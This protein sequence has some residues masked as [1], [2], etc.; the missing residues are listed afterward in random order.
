MA[1][2]R[3]IIAGQLEFGTERVFNQVLEQYTHRMEHY[4]KNDILLKPEDFFKPEDLALDVPR[5]VVIGSERDWL[6]TLNLLERVVSFSMAGSIN[7]WRLSAGNIMD[8]HVL[9]PHSDRTTVQLFNRG[10]Q[11]V[12]Q[13]DKEQEALAMMTKVVGRFERH[14]QA[15]ERR[16]FVNLRLRNIDDAI[17]DYNK[18]L[19]I[20]PSMPESHYGR[21]ICYTRKEMWAEAATDF[22]AVTKNS[23]PHQ[24]I[25]WMAQ[26]ALGDAFLELN[27]PSEASRIFN[28]FSKRKQRIASLDRYDRRVNNIFGK[29]LV[30]AG[31]P[32]DAI[33]AFERSINGVDDPKA[34]SKDEVNYEIGRAYEAG[35][36]MAKA[37]EHWK[38]AGNFAPAKQAIKDASVGA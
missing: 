12:D 25:Y 32:G 23:I 21:G 24:A 11:L 9:E 27:Q 37:T 13:E 28:M 1:E 30:A 4:Y 31:R 8:H 19:S 26:V 15:Y 38:L 29:M 7:M 35:G 2:Y 5:T 20:N 33:F 34:P 3:I 17:Y 22:E 16:G 10:R 14:A 18:S 6:N 36:K